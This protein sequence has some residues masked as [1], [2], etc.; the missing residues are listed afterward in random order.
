MNAV[1]PVNHVNIPK[2][3]SLSIADEVSKGA[4]DIPVRGREVQSLEILAEEFGK[5]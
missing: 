4:D 3:P 1:L 5:D 2:V